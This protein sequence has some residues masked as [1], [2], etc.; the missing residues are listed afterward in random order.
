[1]I[2][3]DLKCSNAHVFEAWFASSSGYEDQQARGLLICP[4]CGDGAIN[5]AVMAPAVSAKGNRRL[6]S[7]PSQ[8]AES[9]PEPT[10]NIPV[11]KPTAPADT[12]IKALIAEMAKAQTKALETSTWVGKEFNEQARAMDAGETEKASIHGEVSRDQAKALVEDGIGVMPLP[13]PIIPPNQ[14]N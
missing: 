8:P 1:M 10:P 13:F 2:V 9:A 5:K 14:R 11:A 3:F 6:V 12:E 7:A 4:L